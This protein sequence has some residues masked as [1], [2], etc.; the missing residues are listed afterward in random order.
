MAR[1]ATR[2]MPR[3]CRSGPGRS[4]RRP[5]DGHPPPSRVD[6]SVGALGASRD[7]KDDDEPNPVVDLVDDAEIGDPQPPEVGSRELRDPWWPRID[8]ERQDRTADAIG[9]AGRQPPELT[10]CGRRQFHP[11]PPPAQ[12]SVEP[13]VALVSA[14]GDEKKDPAV[15]P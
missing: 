3:G 8:G 9:V 1:I 15:S 14:A 7:A 4:S 6:A 12:P 10:L 2:S 11:V 5:A 13:Q